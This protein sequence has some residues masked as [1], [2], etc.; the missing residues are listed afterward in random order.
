MQ[1]RSD[2]TP[3]APEAEC[4][5]LGACILGGRDTV[6]EVIE[7]IAADD[8]YDL[9]H[10]DIMRAI[11]RI[12][13]DGLPLDMVQLKQRLADTGLL[14]RVGGLEYLIMLAESTPHTASATYHA[15][16]VREKAMA[17]R[18]I[19]MAG[20]ILARAED[21]SFPVAEQ[22]AQ[23]EQAIFALSD[24]NVTASQPR[25]IGEELDIRFDELATMET[26]QKQKGVRTGYYELDDMLGGMQAGDMVI[27]A[28]RP[29]MGKTSWALGAALHAAMHGTPTLVFSLEMSREQI[30]DRLLSMEARVQLHRIRRRTVT[31]ED[32]DKLAAA[33]GRI[34]DAPLVIDDAPLTPET[35]RSRAR[36]VAAKHHIGLIVLDYIGLVRSPR[37]ENRRDEI[38]QISRA[39]KAM[40]KEL[41]V[42]VMALS[43]LNRSNESREG[44]RPRMSDLRDSG[45]LEQDADVVVL[46]HREDYYTLKD[47]PHAIPTFMADIDVA[48]QRN[49]PVG[50]VQLRF[51]N[52]TAT[53]Q[54]LATGM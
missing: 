49:G 20:D 13:S 9:R 35:M 16:I 2:N 54:N 34:K 3:S 14:N 15:K 28:A 42:P 40:A 43:Q 23:A 29:S 27:V 48:K 33:L 8:F 46:I 41:R 22:I 45:D 47:D 44:R 38:G 17:R 7:I 30:A 37:A 32:M 51:D 18:L 36:K 26:G 25:G 4:A 50:V 12:T 31:P 1:K 52:E 19:G 6:G 24:N 39:V 21:S 5:V 53:F 10:G 11:M